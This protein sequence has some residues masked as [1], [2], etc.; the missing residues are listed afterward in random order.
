[1]FFAV[2]GAAAV[3]TWIVKGSLF[4]GDPHSNTTNKTD[5]LRSF[6]ALESNTTDTPSPSDTPNGTPAMIALAAWVIAVFVLTII[7]CNK[8]AI[9][10]RVRAF[11]SKIPTT[12]EEEDD[13]KTQ[14]MTRYY[15]IS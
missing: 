6:Q 9:A 13:R 1:M 4:H 15:E 14:E 10:D 5:A 8:A 2:S 12:T 11:F 7:C 3:A